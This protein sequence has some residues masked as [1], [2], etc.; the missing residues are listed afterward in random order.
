MNCNLNEM[1]PIERIRDVRIHLHLVSFLVA[2]C[3]LNVGR[4]I[5]IAQAAPTSADH[6]AKFLE[7]SSLVLGLPH[8]CG[9]SGAHEFGQNAAS[10]TGE[11]VSF[12]QRPC[13]VVVLTA[14][15]G[16]GK[17][18]GC[19]TDL[20]LRADLRKEN[21]VR[22]QWALRGPVPPL[23]DARTTWL[24]RAVMIICR[25][26]KTFP[27]SREQHDKLAFFFSRRRN[28]VDS[29]MLKRTLKSWLEKLETEKSASS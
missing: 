12:R 17:T 29:W 16:G 22:R 27:A 14:L 23:F 3:L 1:R 25:S 24:R 9:D 28:I 11:P 7:T 21:I 5:R 13:P 8:R 4:L 19:A 2:C 6:F 20:Q 10:A 26:T 18:R 15:L